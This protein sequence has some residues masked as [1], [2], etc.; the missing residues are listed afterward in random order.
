MHQFRILTTYLLPI[1]AQF[2]VCQCNDI[3]RDI[4]DRI[5]FGD[6]STSVHQLL[7]VI[8][9]IVF[10]SILLVVSIALFRCYNRY[11]Q[12]QRNIRRFQRPLHVERQSMYKKTIHANGIGQRYSF[13]TVF[14]DGDIMSV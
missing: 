10:V 14:E 8:V 2:P 12:D 1:V 4:F 6:N 11:C 7:S 13:R 5:E 9:V 3:V